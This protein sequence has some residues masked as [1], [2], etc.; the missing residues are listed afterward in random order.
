MF[1]LIKRSISKGGQEIIDNKLPLD[2]KLETTAV[3]ERHNTG[4]NW[5]GLAL[6]PVQSRIWAATYYSRLI[7]G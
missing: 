7:S 6:P 5:K 1:F 4:S 3:W 2:S